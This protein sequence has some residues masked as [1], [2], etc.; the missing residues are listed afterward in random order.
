MSGR[1]PYTGVRGGPTLLPG[2]VHN[3]NPP[4]YNVQMSPLAQKGMDSLGVMTPEQRLRLIMGIPENGAHDLTYGMQG[5]PVGLTTLDSLAKKVTELGEVEIRGRLLESDL[6]IHKQIFPI[7][8][9]KTVRDIPVKWH[10]L[11]FNKGRLVPLP[12]MGI[13]PVLTSQSTVLTMETTRDGLALELEREVFET[14]EGVQ[15]LMGYMEAIHEANKTFVL[16]A[17]YAALMS[18]VD[19]GQAGGA[20]WAGQYGLPL[21][22][23]GVEDVFDY[24]CTISG[25]LGEVNGLPRLVQIGEKIMSERSNL[26]LTHLLV[27]KTTK[28]RIASQAM[29]ATTYLP[30]RSLDGS[31]INDT[32]AQGGDRLISTMNQGVTVIE[33]PALEGDIGYEDV[34][35]RRRAFLTYYT[36]TEA[37]HASL[38]V[39]G[40]YR[41]GLTVPSFH[42]RVSDQISQ[43]RGGKAA[44]HLSMPTFRGE[45]LSA[46]GYNYFDTLL[47]CENREQLRDVWY[48]DAAASEYAAFS[49]ALERALAER[50]LRPNNWFAARFRNGGGYVAPAWGGGGGGGGSRRASAASVSGVSAG[51]RGMADDAGADEDNGAVRVDADAGAPAV[52]RFLQ[53][54]NEATR[55][56]AAQQ[57]ELFPNVSAYFGD[58]PAALVG[59]AAQAK[60]DGQDAP[61]VDA[62]VRLFLNLFG[63]LEDRL[64][65]PRTRDTETAAT[66]ALEDAGRRAPTVSQYVPA[67]WSM[68]WAAGRGTPAEEPFTKTDVRELI[69]AHVPVPWGALMVRADE[70]ECAS[71]IGVS[72]PEGGVG[73]AWVT[74][75][76]CSSSWNPVAGKLYVMPMMRTGIMLRH[77][78]RVMVFPNAL[79]TRRIGGGTMRIFDASDPSKLSTLGAL[80]KDPGIMCLPTRPGEKVRD[81]HKYLPL[82]GAW[83]RPFSGAGHDVDMEDGLLAESY[84]SAQMGR[85]VFGFSDDAGDGSQMGGF[86]SFN[87]NQTN[88]PVA[89]SGTQWSAAPSANGGPDNL[90]AS[91]HYGNSPVRPEYDGILASMTGRSG[92]PVYTPEDRGLARGMVM[93]R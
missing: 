79:V 15:T 71:V 36:M 48:G 38:A 60:D 52:D 21:T 10:K 68:S 28:L 27:P 9:A 58:L 70:F 50:R 69:D 20:H 12:V 8:Y 44:I 86:I 53:S 47:R 74:D 82:S 51:S 31:T 88:F 67:F 77:P 75:T 33:A 11:S 16:Q 45:D 59:A 34:T 76:F 84:S 42:D 65:Q 90:L 92:R 80:G 61:T 87:N 23:Q 37:E 78:E 93:V 63:D 22:Q 35:A 85:D 64:G 83:P 7:R 1:Q 17:C 66:K 29:G 30:G 19:Q 26:K 46:H 39:S 43:V 91:V 56:A 4:G 40:T 2:S 57:R 54:A 25:I 62:E 89:F 5:A 14:D 3:A 32:L 73:T 13:A 6:E 18:V 72:C 24:V 41:S 49:A 81:R 55:R